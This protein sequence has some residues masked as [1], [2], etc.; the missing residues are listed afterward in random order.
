M[1]HSTVTVSEE[2]TMII[3]VIITPG[4]LFNGSDI[5]TQSPPGSPMNTE[6]LQTAT[7]LWTMPTNAEYRP[8]C[9]QLGNYIHRRHLLLPSLKADTHF[10]I[11][12][13]VEG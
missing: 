7:D 9:R 12:Q 3:I 5:M 11:Q 2:V 10:T 4:Q 8:A 1:I 13:R 6:Q